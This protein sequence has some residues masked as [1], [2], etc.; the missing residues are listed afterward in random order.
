MR[1][2]TSEQNCKHLPHQDLRIMILSSFSHLWVLGTSIPSQAKTAAKHKDTRIPTNCGPVFSVPQGKIL[3]QLKSVE[4]PM[5][6]L[7][8]EPWSTSPRSRPLPAP[9]SSE[10][11]DWHHRNT[12]NKNTQQKRPAKFGRFKKGWQKTVKNGSYLVVSIPFHEPGANILRNGK[13]YHQ[14]NKLKCLWIDSTPFCLVHFILKSMAP[15]FFKR[16]WI[17]GPP[18]RKSRIVQVQTTR[19]QFA[20]LFR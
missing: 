3:K 6:Q 18:Q 16:T 8:I 10:K 12:W 5:L 2:E 4:A 11:G 13:V 14:L 7:K 1:F 15:V 20:W 17:F 19:N 9:K